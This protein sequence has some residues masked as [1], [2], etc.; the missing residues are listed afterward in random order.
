[1]RTRIIS[2]IL[3]LTVF[4]T[5]CKNE[6]KETPSAEQAPEVQ[7]NVKITL[8]VTVKKDDDLQ[9]YYT[10]KTSTDFNEK[11]SLWQHVKGSDASQKVVFNIPE[12]ILPTM[13]RLDFG[14]SD[15]QEDIKFSGIEI[16][17]YG[18]K[19]A[20][21][22]ENLANYFRPQTE[23]QIDFKTGMIKALFKDGKR[24]EPA[25]FPHEVPLSKEFDKLIKG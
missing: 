6:T 25:I 24:I 16:E 22:G 3:L 9:V 15:K 21:S 18:K 8:D 23:T 5:G 4:F 14:V 13:V 2:S 7:K 11:E 1:M 19:F 10:E 12:N 20:A 17:Y